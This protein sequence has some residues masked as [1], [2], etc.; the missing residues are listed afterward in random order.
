VDP[1]HPEGVEADQS[2]VLVENEKPRLLL[3]LGKTAM[4]DVG[5]GKQGMGGKSGGRRRRNWAGME[6][7]RGK[8]A[9][10]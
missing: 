10:H 5:L 2:A 3:G 7:G 1:G 8:A 4:T 6:E 9:W